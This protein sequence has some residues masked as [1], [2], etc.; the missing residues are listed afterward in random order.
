MK[1]N[2]LLF[3]AFLFIML[4]QAAPVWAEKDSPVKI[5]NLEVSVMPEYDTADVLVLNTINF[6]N[7]TDQPFSGEIRFP[8]PKRTTNNI[9]KETATNNDNHLAV[10]VEDR[11][12]YSEFVWQPTQSIQP[13]VAYPVHLEFYYN[14][15]P[16]TGNKE[17]TYF[18]KNSMNTDS[19]KINLQ[20]PLT[21]QNFKMEP[22]GQLLGQDNAGFKVYGF[23]FTGLKPG[24]KKDIKISYTKNDPNP[25]MQKPAANSGQTG[26]GA[27][28]GGGMSTA[29]IAIPL[30]A[31]V[32]LGVI[33]AVKATGS[34]ETHRYNGRKRETKG[35]DSGKPFNSKLAKE[36]KRLRQM[37][38]NGEISEETYHELLMDIEEEYS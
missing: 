17:F 37:L 2:L 32:F 15:L 19:M 24:D 36:K 35:K 28:G 8:V 31:L 4:L 33:I 11:G 14:P 16:G 1:K 3:T 13:N 34:R 30:V 27:S 7:T 10:R 23:N 18:Y 26:A 12:D 21:A 38:L 25:S 6:I 22:V 20:Q 29:A 9:V 5:S